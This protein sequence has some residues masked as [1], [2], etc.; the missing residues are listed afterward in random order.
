[1]QHRCLCTSSVWGTCSG[2]P[3]LGTL[4]VDKEGYRNVAYL[5]YTGFIRGSWTEGS[6]TKD[7]EIHEMGRLWKWSISFMG[8]NKWNL[9]L[10]AR[11]VKVKHSRYRPELV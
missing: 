2:A 3:L 6:D 7:Y 9:R 11:E 1:M 10:V 4:E 8:L 5:C